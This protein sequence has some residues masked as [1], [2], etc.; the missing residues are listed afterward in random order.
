MVT[1]W[2]FG[3]KVRGVAFFDQ[4]RFKPKE[5]FFPQFAHF[6]INLSFHAVNCNKQVYNS[7][8][9][10]KIDFPVSNSGDNGKITSR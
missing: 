1:I 7:I 10:D 3:L 2:R 6:A 8:R 4:G 5:V 9:F